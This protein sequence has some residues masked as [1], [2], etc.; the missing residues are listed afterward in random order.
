MTKLL[1]MP[2]KY[3]MEMIADW[4]GAGKA[5]GNSDTLG[6]YTKNRDNIL[7]NP[8]TRAE[9]ERELRYTA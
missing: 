5:L 6:W 2:E 4:R 9:V 7:L 8:E 3:R 1:P